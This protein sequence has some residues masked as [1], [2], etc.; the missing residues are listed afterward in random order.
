MLKLQN[1]AISSIT[2]VEGQAE[3]LRK[4][5]HSLANVMDNVRS[6]AH[7]STLYEKAV[8][9]CLTTVL[10]QFGSDAQMEEMLANMYWDVVVP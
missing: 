9:H 8:K 5:H 3:D 2:F 4:K 6:A 1:G 10:P 7:K